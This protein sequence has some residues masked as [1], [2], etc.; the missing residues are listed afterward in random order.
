[1]GVAQ[2]LAP[3]RCPLHRVAQLLEPLLCPFHLVPSPAV[4][5]PRSQPN[6]E[7]VSFHWKR[8][9]SSPYINP[10][11]WN[12]NSAENCRTTGRTEDLEADSHLLLQLPYFSSYA[13]DAL[14]K[15]SSALNSSAC[16]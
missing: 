16:P 3:H 9:S 7:I 2:P 4:K 10:K 12:S 5:H 6:S 13:V 1:M 14:V 15:V 11:A 8:C